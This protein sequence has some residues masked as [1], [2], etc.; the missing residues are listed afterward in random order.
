MLSEISFLQKCEA[1]FA[2]KCEGGMKRREESSNVEEREEVFRKQ[3]P[4]YF[5]V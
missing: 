2:C 4:S 1:Q 3:N 5:Q